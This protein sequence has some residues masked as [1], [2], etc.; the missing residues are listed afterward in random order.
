MCD[1]CYSNILEWVEIKPQGRLLTYT[2]IHIA[3]TAFQPIAPYIVGIVE[4]E[5]DL[6][7]PAMI[8]NVAFEQVKIGMNLKMIF[9]PCSASSSQWPQWPRYHFEPFSP[10]N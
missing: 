6:K 10:E 8:K 7:I 9:E 4:L 1:N 5:N 3:P 2:V